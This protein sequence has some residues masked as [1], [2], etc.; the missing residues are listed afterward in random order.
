M[1]RWMRNKLTCNSALAS[2]VV[3]AL[4]MPLSVAAQPARTEVHR[5]LFMIALDNLG[6]ARC[7]RG[8]PCAP[9]TAEERATPPI[10]TIRRGL[11]WRPGASRW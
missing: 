8:Q 5:Q 9:A 7:E 10:L 6:R 11:W 3:L 4:P 2:L 1:P